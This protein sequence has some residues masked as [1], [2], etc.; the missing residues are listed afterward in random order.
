VSSKQIYKLSILY[1]MMKK[2][3]SLRILVY[4]CCALIV[5]LAM[6][7]GGCTG[8]RQTTTTT[9]APT[10][11]HTTAPVITTTTV[12]ET[13]PPAVKAVTPADQSSG[14]PADS[15]ISA[16]FSE[17]MEPASINTGVF[18]LGDGSSM[19]NGTV[20][21][22]GTTA[23]FTPLTA[24]AAGKKYTANINQ[25]ARDLAGNGLDKTY[26]WSFTTGQPQDGPVKTPADTTPPTVSSVSPLKGAEGVDINSKIEIVFSE[27][28][29][30]ATIDAV[31]V[32]AIS[33]VQEAF[34]EGTLQYSGSKAVFT[35]AKPLA[36]SA[37]YI[38]RISTGVKDKA[39]NAMAQEFTW[40]FK[41]RP[42]PDTTAPTVLSV[43][44]LNLSKNAAANSTVTAT[45]SETMDGGTVTAAT[46]FL[47]KGQTPVTGTVT[48][49]NN[50]AVFVPQ[51][52]L[53]QG[54]TYT[55]T[56][57]TGLKDLAGNPLGGNYQWS[58]TVLA[59]SSGGGGGGGGSTT[60][61]VKTLELGDDSFPET[62]IEGLTLHYVAPSAANTGTAEIKAVYGS[63]D[64]S[65]WV[66]ITDDK[67]WVGHVP[68]RAIIAAMM[69]DLLPFYDSLGLSE[70]ATYN[71]SDSKYWFFALPSWLDITK[72][73]PAVTT[74]PVF[75]SIKSTGGK[76]IVKYQ[77]KN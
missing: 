2:K 14:N 20:T 27:E 11:T 44:P 8:S 19:L 18:T 70:C 67:L 1:M 33:S 12:K 62:G 76:L 16:T 35:P 53:S 73:D 5:L 46:F 63:A 74:L 13:T 55:A 31:S 15:L 30:A 54:T 61:P 9:A 3:T 59:A 29:D 38:F 24:L 45:F 28:M 36:Y 52:P 64:W 65:A 42:L 43:S 23:V 51:A 48:L 47:H 71:E 6:T 32:S 69:P 41:T 66:G 57:T 75:I 39:G 40:S 26:T 77:I 7:A 60:T 25:G 4:C 37:S 50:Q 56:L 58:F 72:Y 10:T 34:L 21:Y 17:A 49:S 22:S 68:S